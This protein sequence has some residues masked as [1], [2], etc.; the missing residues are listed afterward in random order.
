MGIMFMIFTPMP[1]VDAS[2][3][4][5]FR[6]RYQRMLVGAGGMIFELFVAAIA[7]LVW[8]QTGP[9]A[10]HSV[11]Y[12]MMFVASVSTLL[13]NLNPLMRFDGYYLLSDL[14]EIP[15]LNQRA[16]RQ[17]RY[18][19]EKYLLGVAKAE[20][21]AQTP[22]ESAWLTVF[23]IGAG[24]YRI[25]VFGG[26][27][28]FIADR[29]MLLGIIMAAV[30][31]V[32]WVITPI[33]GLIR[34]LASSP[35]LDRCR[36]RAIGVTVGIAAV[37]VALLQFTPLPAHFR[38]PGVLR[39]P[40]EAEVHNNTAGYLEE[41]VAKPGATVTKGQPLL[42]MSNQELEINLRSALATRDEIE[43]HILQSM[44][45]QQANLRPL[46]S[47][48]AAAQQNI[49]RLEN[50]RAELV[51]H[52]PQA[53]TWIAPHIADSRH[54]WML[55]GADL[56]LVT[57]PAKFQFIAVV[58]QIDADR[59]FARP[60]SGS[61]VRLIGEAHSALQVA[62]LKMIPGERRT[63]P[64]P[65]LGW[66][67]GGPIAVSPDDPDG[68]RTVEPFFEVRA[69]L[70]L[71]PAPKATLLD[72]RSGEIRFDLPSEPLLPRWTRQLRQLLQ[73]RYQI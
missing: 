72:G 70:A 24:L 1:Y 25:V 53:G 30:C 23:G 37:L 52:A 11:A 39:S 17:L 16:M 47:R 60:V 35:R 41:I 2:S 62:N 64:S 61:E 55:R 45:Q 63:L 22:K 26:I 20:P 18:W 27:L 71:T 73:K 43:A 12:N 28:L 69:D 44:E 56:G 54:R 49:A 3:S 68:R 34:Y 4:W 51:V 19:A 42:R 59:I 66:A 10:L 57:D 33:I 21:A 5:G 31:A 8:R 58:A 48:L 14:L 9:G 65:A 50:D 36:T 15:N 6:H 46:K 7:A 13:F 32:A 38:A 67:G 40:E 29:F